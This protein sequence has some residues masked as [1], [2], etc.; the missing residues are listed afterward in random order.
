[1]GAK[2]NRGGG[3]TDGG[4]R[5]VAN[6]GRRK[7]LGGAPTQSKQKP[8]VCQIMWGQVVAQIVKGRSWR[9]EMD[10]PRMSL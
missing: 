3:G 6:R 10:P 1:M 7:T 9:S 4:V 8:V 2:S 5:T